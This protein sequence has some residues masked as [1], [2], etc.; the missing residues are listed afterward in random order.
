M[1][2]T[3][4]MGTVLVQ[5]GVAGVAVF[6]LWML[7]VPDF[8]NGMRPQANESA[9]IATLHQIRLAERQFLKARALDQDGDGQGEAGFVGELTGAV[10]L[11]GGDKAL[12]KPLLSPTLRVVQGRVHRSGY[13]FELYL[14][15]EGGTWVV[16]GNQ[17]Q[18]DVDA[19]EHGFAVCAWPDGAEV[20]SRRAF[21]LDGD[22]VVWASAN[23][24][25]RYVG[26]GCPM[27]VDAALPSSVAGRAG[28]SGDQRVGRD[29]Q[30]WTRVR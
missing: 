2:S 6:A 16:E 15:G 3:R 1:N 13:W 9:A 29:G 25:E 22:G 20:H 7:A 28:R 21:F 8:D 24:D 14:P 27:P 17:A 11:R 19:S 18:I 30:S 5:L 10:P 26:T 4:A 23:A 12:A